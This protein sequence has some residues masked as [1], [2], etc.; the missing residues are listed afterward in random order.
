MNTLRFKLSSGLI[1]AGLLFACS[2][3]AAGQSVD[4]YFGLNALTASVPA[5][6][7]QLG[8]GVFPEV[9]GD[10]IFFHGLG[11]GADVSWRGSQNNYGGVYYRPLY[12]DF[13]AVWQP[14]G[15]TSLTPFH[16]TPVLEA[17]VGS[18]SL[19][20]Y[21]NQY[22][23]S[24]FGGCSNYTSSNHFVGHLAVMVKFYITSRIFIAP[25]AQLFIIR[26]DT[27]FGASTSHLYGIALGYT[28]S[29]NPL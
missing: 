2:G 20:V 26:H 23:C 14:V 4:A 28:L 3:L 18:Q 22:T 12:Y 8:G 7:A 13:N 29:A 9:G 16:I 24:F 10:V 19:R 1:L 21:Q 6:Y 11:V 17:G 27:E 15:F 25:Q 5:G